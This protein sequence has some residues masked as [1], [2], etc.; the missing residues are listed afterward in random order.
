MSNKDIVV[1]ARVNYLPRINKEYL[2][3]AG[4]KHGGYSRLLR[5]SASQVKLIKCT[6]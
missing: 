3:Q 1:D 6:L 2:Y 4:N 5:R